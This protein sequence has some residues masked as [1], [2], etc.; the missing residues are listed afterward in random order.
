MLEYIAAM[1]PHLRADRR[2]R[3]VARKL[4][5]YRASAVEALPLEIVRHAAIG[6]LPGWARR[7]HGLRRSGLARPFVGG[8]TLALAHTLRWAFRD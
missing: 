5:E 6:L 7:M 3:E 1:R 2:T 4:L 8:T